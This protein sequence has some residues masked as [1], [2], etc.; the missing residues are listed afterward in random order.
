[1]KTA[2][3]INLASAPFRRDRPILVASTALGVVLVVLL[4]VQIYLISAATDEGNQTTAAIAAVQTELGRL[5]SEQNRLKGVLAEPDNAAVLERSLF[6]NALLMRKGISWTFIFRD[7]EEVL[8]YNVKLIQV[9]PKVNQTSQDG[10]DNEI[11][12]DMVVAAEASD[13]VIEMLQALESSSLFG[14][15]SVS[16]LSPPTQADPLHRY[17]ISVR[18]HREL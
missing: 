13:Q 6:L 17:Q 5:A 4:G 7:L 3:A 18:Y 1:M 2:S 11:L 14:E 8:P 15:T 9:R 10:I 16:T 12:L